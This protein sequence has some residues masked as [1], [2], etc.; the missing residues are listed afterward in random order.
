MQMEI[1]KTRSLNCAENE[2][3]QDIP[4]ADNLRILRLRSG[5]SRQELADY[6]R[7][8]KSV[9]ACYEY[10]YTVPPIVCLVR[11]CQLYGLTL[12]ELVREKLS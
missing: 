7:V 12:D 9:Y 5:C 11:L 6:L 3:M 4:L 1:K 10:G 2:K 8:H